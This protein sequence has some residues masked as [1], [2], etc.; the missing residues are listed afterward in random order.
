MLE[1]RVETKGE[2]NGRTTVSI[3]LGRA[4]INGLFC[5]HNIRVFFLHHALYGYVQGIIR[6]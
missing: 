3:Y 4:G 6:I 5:M 1:N 2:D